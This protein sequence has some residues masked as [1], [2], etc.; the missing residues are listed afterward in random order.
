MRRQAV[1]TAGAEEFARRVFPGAVLDWDRPGREPCSLVSSC[2]PVRVGQLRVKGANGD[3]GLQ[4][5]AQRHLRS[6]SGGWLRL[7]E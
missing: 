7:F 1:E 2:I 6:I 4:R 3:G 5:G